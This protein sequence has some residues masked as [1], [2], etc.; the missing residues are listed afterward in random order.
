[1][2]AYDSAMLFVLISAFVLLSAFEAWWLKRSLV[3][4][5]AM[6]AVAWPAGLLVLSVAGTPLGIVAAIVA[7]SFDSSLS[8]PQKMMVLNLVSIAL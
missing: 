7:M 3:R 2:T 1:M 8:D 4:A 5:A 6:N